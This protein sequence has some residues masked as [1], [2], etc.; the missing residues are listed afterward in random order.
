MSLFPLG[1]GE[2]DVHPLRSAFGPFA[3]ERE[4]SVRKKF[5]ALAGFA[6]G[7]PLTINRT[8]ARW[9]TSPASP[10]RP[11]PLQD[12]PRRAR[13]GRWCRFVTLTRLAASI[14][15]NLAED[16]AGLPFGS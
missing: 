11:V 1:L 4:M 16:S 9:S 13:N 15:D 10:P 8:S 7:Q 6:C 14:P 5:D 3:R 12:V 2:G